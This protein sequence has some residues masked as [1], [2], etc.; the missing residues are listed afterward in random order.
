MAQASYVNESSVCKWLHAYVNYSTFGPRWPEII[1]DFREL[2]KHFHSLFPN[3]LCFQ[4]SKGRVTQKKSLWLGDNSKA[5]SRQVDFFLEGKDHT[6]PYIPSH[7]CPSREQS[8]VLLFPIKNWQLSQYTEAQVCTITQSKQHETQV[9]K[10]YSKA[11]LPPT[12]VKP[13]KGESDWSVHDRQEWFNLWQSAIRP[14]S[15]AVWAPGETS[16]S[17]SSSQTSFQ[18]N[19]ITEQ[20]T[21]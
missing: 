7:P 10:L 13:S 1:R 21:N 5:G 18:L 19:A 14:T 9:T 11:S 20:L 6:L 4:L 2:S 16:F 8:F 12:R 17:L 15:S 3:F